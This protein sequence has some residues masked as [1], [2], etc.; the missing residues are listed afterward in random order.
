M[1]ILFILFLFC[2]LGF[3]QERRSLEQRL[4]IVIPRFK[5][6]ANVKEIFRALSDEIV[7]KDPDKILVN[8]IYLSK[9]EDSEYDPFNEEI[10]SI[11]DNEVLNIDFEGLTFHQIIKNICE[12]GNLRYQLDNNAVLISH[13]NEKSE[14]LQTVFYELPLNYLN[15]V[16]KGEM[17]S[18]LESKSVR[19]G[20]ETSL[21]YLRTVNRLAITNT[22]FEHKKISKLFSRYDLENKLEKISKQLN[23]LKATKDSKAIEAI[24]TE[25]KEIKLLL[26]SKK[27]KANSDESEV[28]KSLAVII[29]KVRFENRDLDFAVDYLKRRTR[30]LR[31]GR[32]G[33]NI[34]ASAEK[35]K[36]RINLSLDN[37]SAQDLIRYI[38]LQL[39]L[40]YKVENDTV[41]IRDKDFFDV[42]KTQFYDLSAG[43]LEY[44]ENHQDN[45]LEKA[46]ESLGVEFGPG[47]KIKYVKSAMKVVITNDSRNHQKLKE[48][49]KFFEG[50]VKE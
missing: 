11:E 10:N 24:K 5:A 28:E 22:V 40:N 14:K 1:R 18:F 23:D 30:D 34:I 16:S 17:K 7:S 15:K 46:L 48:V 43:L 31:G 45:D 49:F 47:S 9:A 29:P 50:A 13:P 8:I 20:K 6:I 27:Q 35:I 36:G 26:E 3:S 41:F 21:S 4:E 25:F 39:N 32:N 37:I 19:F 38:C 2:S 42:L 33:L 44:V 12:M